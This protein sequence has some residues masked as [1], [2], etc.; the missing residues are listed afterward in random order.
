M[1][2]T[3]KRPNESDSESLSDAD[4]VSQLSL[5]LSCWLH[6]DDISHAAK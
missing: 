4:I 3:V 2:R 1:E 6:K 5:S